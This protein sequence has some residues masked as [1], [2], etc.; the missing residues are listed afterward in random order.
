M[1]VVPALFY[2]G[3]VNTS[4]VSFM[5]TSLALGQSDDCPSASQVDMKDMGEKI[6]WITGQLMIHLKGKRTQQTYDIFYGIYSMFDG[7]VVFYFIDPC[8]YK[9][10]N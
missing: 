1:P 3:V 2:F 6:T 10:H 8:V 5:I 4:S 7:D 9:L